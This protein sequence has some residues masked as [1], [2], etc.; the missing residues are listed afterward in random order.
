RIA[1]KELDS[2][3]CS[4]GLL[5]KIALHRIQD[6]N[7]G[8]GLVAQIVYELV[9]LSGDFLFR[10]IVFDSIP[11]LIERGDN[12]AAITQPPIFFFI[13]IRNFPGAHE[14]ERPKAKSQISFDRD[15]VAQNGI[16]VLAA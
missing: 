2:L 12:P 3:R 14:R 13:T 6:N 15:A 1:K 7:L 5:G 4:N 11:S 10:Q 9:D 8:S 16:Q